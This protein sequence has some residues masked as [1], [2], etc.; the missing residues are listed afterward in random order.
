M[1]WFRSEIH[2]YGSHSKFEERR[3]LNEQFSIFNVQVREKIEINK[4][5]ST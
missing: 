2:F 1:K 3:M 4:A 5:S